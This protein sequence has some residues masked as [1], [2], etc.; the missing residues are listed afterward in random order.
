MKSSVVLKEAAGIVSQVQII[1]CAIRMHSS[2][3]IVTGNARAIRH[4]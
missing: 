3:A 2:A 4:R 1:N